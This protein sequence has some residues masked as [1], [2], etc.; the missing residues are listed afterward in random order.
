MGPNLKVEGSLSAPY[1]DGTG[2]VNIHKRLEVKL[3]FSILSQNLNMNLNLL[4]LK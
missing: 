4:K 2:L 3:V 1:F